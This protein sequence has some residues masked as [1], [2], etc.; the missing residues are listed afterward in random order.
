MTLTAL[1]PPNCS[2]AVSVTQKLISE[3]TYIDYL[4]IIMNVEIHRSHC[5]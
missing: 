3:A 4:S 5:P 1:D 2:V